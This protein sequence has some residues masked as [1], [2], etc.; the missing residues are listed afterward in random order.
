MAI[1]II[2]NYRVEK[3]LRKIDNIKHAL[4]DL[5]ISEIKV[6]SY[7]EVDQSLPED[8]KAIILSGS[9][10]HLNEPEVREIYSSEIEFVKRVN[11]PILGICFGH[12]LIGVAFGSTVY[13][14]SNPIKGFVAVKILQ[15][16]A[17]FSSWKEGD[18]VILKQHHIDCLSEL[19]E[20]FVQLAESESCKIEAMAHHTKP[21]YGIQAHIERYD[22]E[23][24]HGLQVLK[25][26]VENVVENFV[27]EQIIETKSLSEIKQNM[28]NSLKDIVYDIVKEDWR[29]VESK[30]KDA[31]K[32]IDAYMVKKIVDALKP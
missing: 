25:N 16:H 3:G 14:L 22:R 11:V 9:E 23:H 32:Y 8:V 17:I 26:F 5:G 6:W 10:S 24:P 19:P 21:I 30:L 18:V 1:L 27:F 28:I 31:K 12:Q 20:R 7:S 29:T 4:L 2:N 13:S 15:P